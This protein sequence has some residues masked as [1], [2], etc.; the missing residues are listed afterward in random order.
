MRADA[1]QESYAEHCRPQ[2]RAAIWQKQQR[3]AGDRHNAHDHAYIDEKVKKE[4]AEY[5]ACNVATVAC[6]VA[7]DAQHAQ[8]DDAV[9]YE[10]K[11]P[12]EKAE[13]FS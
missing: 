1:H 4:H 10:H 6:R 11:K 3:Y 2:R 7:Y 9:Q 8:K 5:A 12:A 13:F